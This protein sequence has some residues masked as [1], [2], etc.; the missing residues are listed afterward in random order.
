VAAS[1]SRDKAEIRRAVASGTA[2]AGS[3]FHES[4]LSSGAL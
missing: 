1:S 3:H 2:P 4:L